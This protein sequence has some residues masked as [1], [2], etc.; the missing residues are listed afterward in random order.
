MW[1]SLLSI[2]STTGIATGYSSGLQERQKS[3][4]VANAIDL[5]L[6]F[7]LGVAD[8]DAGRYDLARQRFEYILGQEPG[9]PG[10]IDRLAETLILLSNSAIPEDEVIV[11]LPTPSPTPDTRT[12]DEL[13][14]VAQGQ[15]H[16]Q[17]WKGLLQTILA[18]RD[19]DPLYQ[20]SH[21][22]R[23][24]FLA[25]RNAGI[26]KI[27]ND[28]DLEGGLYDLSLAEQFVFLDAQANTYREWAYLYQFG[29]SFWGLFP[30][31]VVDYFSQLASAAPFLHD[32]SDIFAKD[33]YRMALLVY[34]DHLVELGGWCAAAEQY[35]LAQSLLDDQGV[36]LTLVAAEEQCRV[37]NGIQSTPI[38]ADNQATLTPELTI[39]L[40]A[41]PTPEGPSATEI[42]TSAPDTTTPEPT[43]TL[44]STPTPETP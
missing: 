37:M 13:F 24:L 5:G 43:P 14:A 23:M 20:V 34:G 10:V 35:T 18:L 19:I 33:R 7:E 4:A 42:P 8:L 2:F 15:L 30:D 44:E 9:F 32:F 31:K 11:P 3:L 12:I 1:I 6:Q 21:V 25:L 28:G 27:I 36:Q 29:V 38:P 40:E 22:D 16:D 26:E 17:N 41:T 39:T